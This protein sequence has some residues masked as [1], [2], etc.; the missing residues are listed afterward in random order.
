M[1]PV[2]VRRSALG[3]LAALCLVLLIVS[4]LTAPFSTMTGDLQASPSGPAD[5][6]QSEKTQT[7]AVVV[8]AFVHAEPT[9][10]IVSVRALKATVGA[11]FARV[12]RIL[13]L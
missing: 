11:E 5:S 9:W 4:P 2:A 13:R 6:V 7:D 8:L 1:T 12:N 3:R 10:T